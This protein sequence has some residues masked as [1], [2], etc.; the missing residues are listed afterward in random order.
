MASV[1]VVMPTFKHERFIRRALESLLAQTWAAWEL[2]VV[3]DGSPDGTAAVVSPYLQ[4]QRIHYHRLERNEGLG[5][6]LNAGL[7]L[8][9]AELV[10]YLPSD[11]LYYP[12]HLASLAD[13]LLENPSAA[14]AFSGVRFHYNRRSSGQVE[15]YPLQLVQVMHRRTAERWIER[16]ELTTDDLERMFW[17]RLRPSGE[18]VGT[19]QVTCEWVAHPAQRHKILREPEGGI[20]L[21]R[22]Y[23]GT[24]QP[25]R[26]HTSVGNYI[27]EVQHYRR[28]RERADTP[29]AAD[30]L[31]IVLV[32]EL[33]YN[34]ERVLALEELGHKLY[35]LWMPDPYWYNTV[36]P[37]PF[38]HVEDI[39]ADNWRESL[40]RIQPDLIYALL[41]W[42]AVPFA[43]QVLMEN[44]GI[45]FIWHFKE[46]P[47]ICLEKGMWNELVDLHRLSDGQIYSTPEM[48]DWFEMAIPGCVS[49]GNPYVLDGD[50]PKRDWFAGER[51]PRLSEQ[52]GELHTVVPGRPIGLH[53]EGVAELA[54]LRIHL[55]F[56]GDFTHGQW[57]QWIERTE[58]LASGF[59][60]L[61]PHADQENW[62]REF[63]QYDAGW[64]HFFRSE[65]RGELRRA[66]W[67]DLNYP[68]RIATLAAAGLPM[69]QRDNGD[70]LVASQNL[71]RSLD[72]GFF[73]SEMGELAALLSDRAR[74]EAV[75]E[76]VWQQ[77]ER[78]TFDMHA[79]ALIDHFRRVMQAR[80][81][82]NAGWL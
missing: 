80:R 68:A 25:L 36:G 48:R 81:N 17:T 50:L 2:W 76:S 82:K 34:A 12:E 13:C 15:G 70:A 60:H 29:P 38:G 57:Q 56:Y 20:N 74:L 24:S 67:D 58:R 78:F 47:F 69:L 51:R 21:Y 39:P 71:V 32:G 64:L 5:A 19:D 27:D 28:Y 14:A 37:L 42:Q 23:T 30:G 62:V 49:G 43:H 4:D 1:S 54:A 44:P 18:F 61:H 9:T 8:S 31:K 75:R 65:N 53:P 41:N 45:P 16:D 72:L 66:D 46:G 26:F 52:D 11:D 40:L 79:P 73:F 6:A 59:I 33:A 63:S 55:H 10:A 7:E 35:G 77:R 3:D 22:Q